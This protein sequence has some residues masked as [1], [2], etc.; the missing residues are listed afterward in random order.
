MK[1]SPAGEEAFTIIVMLVV[2][3]CAALAAMIVFS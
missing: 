1:L 3:G 2:I